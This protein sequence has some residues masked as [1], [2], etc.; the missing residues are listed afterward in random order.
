MAHVE[1]AVVHRR[2]SG[3]ATGARYAGSMRARVSPM[4]RTALLVFAA[5]L[6]GCASPRIDTSF[7]AAS[8]D[9]RVQFL[10]LHYTE[11]DF[12][13]ALTILT[14]GAVS[15]HYLVR[16]DPPT[17]YRL[18]DESRRAWH[19]GPSSWQGHTELNA[20]SIGIEIVNPGYRDT[21]EGRVWVDYPPAQIDAVVA[22]VKK[23]VAEHGIRADRIVGH[24]D[25]APQRKVDPGPR[26]PW[27]RLADE[28]LIPWPD[29]GRVASRKSEYER[30]LPDI[31]WFQAALARFGYAAPKSG[32]LDEPTR[33]VIAAFQ[34][35]YRQEKFDGMPDAE[36][37][38]LLD[39][40]TSP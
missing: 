34:M 6:A 14:E 22:L 40:L 9:S 39:A 5:L 24:S 27:K 15:S 38:A 10:V 18:V 7:V 28:G 23:V 11:G 37:A 30:R 1:E 36:T 31:A 19:A 21:A 16:D 8:Q 25:I 35:R 32:E 4:R 33:R 13:S 17:I 20:A 26:F 3:S 29:A 12:P 2:V